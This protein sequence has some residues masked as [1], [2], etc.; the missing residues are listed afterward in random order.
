M[1]D[2]RSLG[3]N[4]VLKCVPI[5]ERFMGIISVVKQVTWFADVHDDSVKLKPRSGCIHTASTPVGK[6]EGPA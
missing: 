5:L 4:P 2:N 1:E 6:T 3:L